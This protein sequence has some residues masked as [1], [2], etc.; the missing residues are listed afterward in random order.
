MQLPRK[1]AQEPTYMRYWH[2]QRRLDWTFVILLLVVFAILYGIF[3]LSQSDS[4]W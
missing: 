3:A 2:G 4:V 1:S